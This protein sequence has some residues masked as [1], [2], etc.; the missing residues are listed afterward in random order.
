MAPWRRF[1]AL[2]DSVTEGVGDPLARGLRGWAAR[3]AEALAPL[4]DGFTFVNLA[5]RGLTTGEIRD[6]QLERALQLEPDLASAIAGMND[7]IKPWFSEE[8]IAEP[9]EQIVGELSGAGA[10]VLMA[11]LPDV[12]RTLPLTSSRRSRFRGRLE[13]ANVVIRDTAG[14]HPN[15]LLIDARGFAEEMRGGNFSIDRLH[16]N[17][18]GHLMIARAFAERL[19]ETGEA[20]IALPEL[21][22]VPLVG[23]ESLRHAAWVLRNGVGPEVL[24]RAAALRRLGR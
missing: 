5:H 18:R 6:Q 21:V 8:A 4:D 14:R 10:T 1:V 3:L 17:S 2:G 9:L 23:R 22:D 13:A 19:T 11:T 12:T 16:P 20:T 24:R 7:A 15:T